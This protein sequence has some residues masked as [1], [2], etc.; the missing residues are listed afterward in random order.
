MITS[1]EKVVKVSFFVPVNYE[2]NIYADGVR[3]MICDLFGAFNVYELKIKE[4][5]MEEELS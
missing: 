4:T 1:K 3:R 2:K 5:T